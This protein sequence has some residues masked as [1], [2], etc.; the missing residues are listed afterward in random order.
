MLCL[1]R[2][3]MA[4]SGNKGKPKSIAGQLAKLD[5]LGLGTVT[6]PETKRWVARTILFTHMEKMMVRDLR[7]LRDTC[8]PLYRALHERGCGTSLDRLGSFPVLVIQEVT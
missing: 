4:T 3:D 7:N 1:T 6:H 2:S 8:L 5:K